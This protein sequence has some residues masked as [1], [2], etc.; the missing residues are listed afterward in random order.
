M[1]GTRD[2]QKEW[3]AMR[4]LRNGWEGDTASGSSRTGFT[5]IELLVVLAIIAVLIGL[6]L[7]AVQ[8]VREAANQM[9]CRNHLKQLGLALLN[10]ESSRGYLPAGMVTE[11]DLQDSFFTGFTC[12]LPYLEQTNVFNLYHFD[13]QWYDVANYS[14]VEQEV[15]LF[16]CPSNRTRGQ[17]DLG[18][19]I[20]QWGG[21]P[22]PPVVGATDYLLCKGANAGFSDDPTTIPIAVRGLFN[23]SQA[24][25]N[26]EANQQLQWQPRPQFQI[27][28]TDI[29][30]GT[31]NTM[32]LGEGAGGNPLY[33]VEDPKN[34]GQPVREPFTGG[35]AIME[36]AWGAASLTDPS[37]PWYAGIFGVTAQFGMEPNLGNEA[38]NR[39]PGSATIIGA[40]RS[41]YNISGR[42]HVSGFRSMHPGG[43]HFLFADGSVHWIGQTITPALYRC[44]STYAGGDLASSPD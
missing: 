28:I 11:L 22:M 3:K 43:C 34:P 31:S 6:L 8:K 9:R 21:C 41:G 39:T 12:L 15:P 27:R 16:Y 38:M 10:H 25:V 36:Q 1:P 4:Q 33:P 30:D 13:K 37:H 29:T 7:P 17:M 20:Q 23:I 26:V 24:V 42:D 18:A 5:L 14:A 44:L 2:P 19:A 35:P 40:D 32:A